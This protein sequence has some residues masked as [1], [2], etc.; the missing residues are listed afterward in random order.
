MF[1]EAIKAPGR[2]VRE[3]ERACARTAQAGTSPGHFGEQACVGIEVGC[4]AEREAGA[5]Q[6]VGETVTS[7]HTNATVV[8]ECA[9]ATR[10]GEQVVAGR[11]VD[12]GLRHDTLMREG[13]RH[14]VVRKA[15]DEI[16]GAIE[17]IDDPL[18]F[19]LVVRLARFFGEDRVIR[20]GGRQRIDDCRF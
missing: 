5:D 13:D 16:R 14:A 8:Q 12:H 17:W 9:A 4:I 19:G 3:I 10:G 11:V 1:E 6:A 15:M 7:R 20:V 18:V 2:D